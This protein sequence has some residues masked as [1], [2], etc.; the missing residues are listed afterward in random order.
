MPILLG[1]LRVKDI[2]ARLGIDLTESERDFLEKAYQPAAENVAEGKWHC[3]DI[4]FAM[5]CGDFDFAHE[6]YVLLK[7]YG[8]QMKRQLQISVVESLQ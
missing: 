7:P 3:F 6:V 5:V 2:E 4:P 1:D 8:K